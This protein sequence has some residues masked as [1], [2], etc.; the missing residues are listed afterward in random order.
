MFIKM[1]DTIA[2]LI[3]LRALPHTQLRF[4]PSK[5]GNSWSTL[6]AFATYC[7]SEGTCLVIIT[8]STLGSAL[9]SECDSQN[10]G[11]GVEQARD[12][13]LLHDQ[14]LLLVTKFTNLYPLRCKILLNA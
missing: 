2:V 6:S 11:Q 12:L 7:Y 10:A 8:I 9:D 14:L 5:G 3:I 4:N 1:S 13:Q